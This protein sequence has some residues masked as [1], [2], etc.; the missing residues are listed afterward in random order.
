M[1]RP[2]ARKSGPP[3]MLVLDQDNE[4][5]IQL[6]GGDWNCDQIVTIAGILR[7]ILACLHIPIDNP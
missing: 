3:I 5:G 6:E 2:S 7:Y 1:V 4:A